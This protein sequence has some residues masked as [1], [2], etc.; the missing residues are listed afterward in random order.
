MLDITL[1][2]SEIVLAVVTMVSHGAF[3]NFTPITVE[4][5][6]GLPL[7]PSV[8]SLCS[9]DRET[10]QSTE[11]SFTACGL[12]CM[13]SSDCLGFNYVNVSGICGTFEKTQPAIFTKSSS[14]STCQYYQ[15]EYFDLFSYT[16]YGLTQ[17]TLKYDVSF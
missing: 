15:V 6:Y 11:F 5:S 7:T 17:K 1:I 10:T 12:S 8:F 13:M 2:F 3:I 9:L 4:L 14:S 16:V